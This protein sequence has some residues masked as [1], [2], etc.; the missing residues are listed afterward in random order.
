MNGKPRSTRTDWAKVDATPG[1][2]DEVSPELTQ[3]IMDRATI[4]HGDKIIR[5]P[6]K[7]GG[8]FITSAAIAPALKKR[9]RPVGSKKQSIHVRVDKDVLAYFKSTGRGWQ[10]RLN[11][12]LRA[13]LPKRAASRKVAAGVG[14]R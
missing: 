4:Y 3:D 6:K 7:P 10:T 14:K 1:I 11:A 9:G 12:V 2:P 5:G 8:A 13:S